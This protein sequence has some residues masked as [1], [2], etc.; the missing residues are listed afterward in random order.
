[1]SITPCGQ[2]F[3][4]PETNNYTL[5]INKLIVVLN[6]IYALKDRIY[7]MEF[8]AFQFCTLNLKYSDRKHCLREFESQISKYVVTNLYKS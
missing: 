8:C 1:M 6:H 4:S 2:P 5:Q 7:R 3:L